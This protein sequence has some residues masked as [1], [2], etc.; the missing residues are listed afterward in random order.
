M[1][2]IIISEDKRDLL[3]SMILQES[4]TDGDESD[5]VLQIK[6]FLDDN[7]TK[8]SND[9]GQFDDNG[10]RTTQSY[11]A[12]MDKNKNILKLMTDRQVFDLLQEKFK[13]IMPN[14][15]EEGKRNRDAFLKKVLIAW[16]NNKITKNG[17]IID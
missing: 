11:A 7:F 1:K 2:T 6:K 5:K 4:L 12:L 14:A 9:I 13:T 15:D 17:S 3:M 16:Y 8:A 10:N